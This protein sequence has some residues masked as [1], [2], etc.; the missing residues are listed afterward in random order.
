[1]HGT[2]RAPTVKQ[3]L[4]ALRRLFDWLV[5][6]QVLP[7]NP[8]ASVRGP[9]HV[10]RTGKTPVLQPAE[11]R[12]LLDAIET[13]TLPGLRD[14]ALL[15]VMV[16]SFARVSAVVNMRVED[17]YQQGKRWWLR[18]QEKGGK[19][20]AVP[21]HHKAEACLDAYLDAA[22]IAAEKSAPL[23]RSMPRARRAPDEPGG[24][25]SDGQTSDESRRARPRG[26][27][28]HLPGHRHHGVS[29]QRR[30]ARARSGDRRA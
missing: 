23:W 9:T 19:H 14:R 24:C 12:L 8:A 28:P 29:A 30:H 13:S 15:G 21:V 4:A 17:Y 25:V 16:Y 6:G 11:A 20:H 2:Y 27:L 22:G 5:I 7:A 1:M 26:E 3:H 18:L 10:V